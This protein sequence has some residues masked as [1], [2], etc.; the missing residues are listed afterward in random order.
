MKRLFGTVSF[1]VLFTIP[2]S[3]QDFLNV[4]GNV[5]YGFGMGGY[6]VGSSN[7]FLDEEEVS[8]STE[9]HFLNLGHGVKFELG[10]GVMLLPFLEARVALDLT[11]GAP[12]PTINSFRSI[13]DATQDTVIDYSYSSYGLRV[14]F[15]P[16]FEVFD[17]VYMYIGTGIVFNSVRSVQEITITTTEPDQLQTATLVNEIPLA[18]GFTGVTGFEL[19]LTETISFMGEIRFEQ[20]NHKL[21]R[22][23]V[24]TVFNFPDMRT[25]TFEQDD[26]ER[27]PPPNIPGTNWGV[28]VGLKVW[29]L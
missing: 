1:I 8:A 17:L 3:A 7:T 27:E 12:S 22:Q 28:R 24:D 9:D 29:V 18:I 11:Q 25:V 4:Y 23:R 5:G 16:Y 10:C 19:P 15:A 26:V 2:L 20:M 14:I 6:F 21:M 13:D